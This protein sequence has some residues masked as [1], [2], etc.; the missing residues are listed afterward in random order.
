[1]EKKIP[2]LASWSD[3]V[4]RLLDLIQLAAAKLRLTPNAN[5]NLVHWSNDTHNA[6][7]HAMPFL[8][9]SERDNLRGFLCCS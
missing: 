9:L 7:G 6:R 5:L 1:M 8:D 4:P 3:P 2:G